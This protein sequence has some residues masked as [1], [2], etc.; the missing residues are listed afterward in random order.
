MQV[1][2]VLE[3]GECHLTFVELL[4]LG[5][6]APLHQHSGELLDLELFDE[7]L[8]LL[9][10]EAE[11]DSAPE[12]GLAGQSLP[13]SGRRLLVREKEDLRLARVRG[14]EGVDVLLC[15]LGAEIGK[16]SRDL[17]G[18]GL[19]L[20]LAFELER[21][22]GVRRID[23]HTGRLLDALLVAEH[24]KVGAADGAHLRHA[25]QVA[26]DLVVLI[27]ESDVGLVVVL[28]EPQAADRG[29]AELRDHTIEVRSGDL[30]DVVPHS[31]DLHLA[32]NQ[33][34]H[35]GAHHEQH[36]WHTRRHCAKT[37]RRQK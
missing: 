8:V 24:G 29:V 36:P 3:A 31:L 28:E 11:L 37:C 1:H 4:N 21:R 22:H 30:L 35:K 18:Q 13:D 16:E 19:G 9:H 14:H 5:F 27:E 23:H 6:G 34:R 25:F 32:L 17:A 26:G 12:D 33:R 20:Q 15:E 7:L 2:P 10:D